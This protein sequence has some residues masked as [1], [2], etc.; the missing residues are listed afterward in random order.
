MTIDSFT[1]KAESDQW[2]KLTAEVH[3][4]VYLA[5]KSAGVSAGATPQGPAA[6]P[7]AT[8]AAGGSAPAPSSPATTAPAATVK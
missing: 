8:P 4:T 7:P 1:W 3:A 2:P 6:A 5:P